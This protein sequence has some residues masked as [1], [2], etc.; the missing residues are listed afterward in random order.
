M[1]I[2]CDMCKRELE[3]GEKPTLFRGSG[4]MLD[5]QDK[6]YICC[7]CVYFI[8]DLIREGR[9]DNMEVPVEE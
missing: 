6:F 2:I 4:T 9:K 8:S 5:Q 3:C 1:A 7:N